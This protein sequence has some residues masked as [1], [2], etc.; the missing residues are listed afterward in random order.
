M[1]PSLSII[2]VNT[3]SGNQL[4]ECLNSIVLTKK[5]G[6]SL[7]QVI[8][9]DNASSD[10]SISGLEDLKLPLVV[11]RNSKNRG[12][13]VACNQG[14]SVTKADYL[15]FLNP[16]TRVF[17]DSLSKPLLFLEEAVHKN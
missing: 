9:V 6:F 7:N 13:A 5:E 12:F 11:I 17:D 16:D 1:G 4:R 10:Q 15:L 8:I 2:L 14:A 3:N